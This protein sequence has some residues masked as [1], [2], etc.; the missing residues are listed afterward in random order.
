MIDLRHRSESA[1][2]EDTA[3]DR[4]RQE[5]VLVPLVVAAVRSFGD[6]V[7]STLLLEHHLKARTRR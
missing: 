5:H 1:R 7:K 6:D 3:R 4:S 2:S